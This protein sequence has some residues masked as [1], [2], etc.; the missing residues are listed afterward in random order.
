MMTEWIFAFGFSRGAYT[1]RVVVGLILSQGLVGGDTD[2]ETYRNAKMA[3]RA[4]RAEKF[5]TFLRI[6]WLFRVIRNIVLWIFGAGYD[7]KRIQSRPRTS[8]LNFSACGAPWRHMYGL[9]VD[10]MTRGISQW[11]WPLEL[12]D[13]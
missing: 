2:A 13:R 8:K 6:E 1:I 7:K 12:P 5:H 3:Y 4:Y 11:I 9:P 10:E